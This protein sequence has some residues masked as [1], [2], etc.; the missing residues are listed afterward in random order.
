MGCNIVMSS[1]SWLAKIS[2]SIR[3]CVRDR[4]LADKIQVFAIEVS[5]FALDLTV[6]AAEIPFS[7]PGDI[8]EFLFQ[9]HTGC[10][11]TQHPAPLICRSG[12]QTVGGKTT[13]APKCF[14]ADLD[15]H[16]PKSHGPLGPSHLSSS[17]HGCHEHGATSGTFGETQ[18]HVEGPFATCGWTF[19]AWRD[20]NPSN[21]MD[22]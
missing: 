21:W 16:P 22:L 9:L 4:N 1:P 8:G 18:Q 12:Y 6:F 19:R 17:L 2:V 13:L 20:F 7:Q 10:L 15:A 14:T 11:Q 5:I 3:Y